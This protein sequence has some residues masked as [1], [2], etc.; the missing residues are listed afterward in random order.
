MLFTVIH[1]E[2]QQCSSGV[3]LTDRYALIAFHYRIVNFSQ[4]KSATD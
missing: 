3:T 4:E 2:I 1:S